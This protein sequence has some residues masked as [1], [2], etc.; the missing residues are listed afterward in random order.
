M[1]RYRLIA[2]DMDG[3][4]LR[5]SNTISPENQY[6]IKRAGEAGVAVCMATGRGRESIIPFVEQLDLN[7]PFAA[8][9]GSEVWKNREQ[10]YHRVILDIDLVKEMFKL[11]ETHDVWFWAYGLNRVH[12]RDNWKGFP[13]D[14]Q[15]LKFGYYTENAQ[16]RLS[17]TKEISSWGRLEITNS[18]PNNM[19]I[20]P[21]GINKSYGIKQL[22]EIIGCGMNEVVAM[23]DSMNDMAMIVDA[24]L[25]VA[26]G[27]AQNVVKQ[28]A[29]VIAPT[30]EEDG[31]GFII[32]KYILG[33][34]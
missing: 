30:N 33:E 34:Q 3:T 22:C 32:R 26:M 31:V 24:G 21:L 20:N 18:N 1:N 2:L 16:I 14:E 11:A 17:I 29:D 9:N 27:N 23:G 6:W 4:L 25:G 8:V 7:T 28:A 15:W 12:N 19:E 13:E 10:L 5:E